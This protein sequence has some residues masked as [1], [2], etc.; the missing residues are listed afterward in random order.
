M[1]AGIERK[2]DHNNAGVLAGAPVQLELSTVQTSIVFHLPAVMPLDA[3]MLSARASELD[4]LV[5]AFWP[6]HHLLR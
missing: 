3:S 2:G 1:R 4:V 5:N 6:A